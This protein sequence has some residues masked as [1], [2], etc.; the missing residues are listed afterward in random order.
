MCREMS[1][2]KR[3]DCLLRLQVV[4]AAGRTTAWTD[5]HLAY[6]E[7]P[8]PTF[9]AECRPCYLRSFGRH[10]FAVILIGETPLPVYYAMKYAAESFYMALAHSC[11]W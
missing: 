9:M 6:G 8:A 10:G 2:G 11:T 1:F 5:K 3:Y 4:K 7:L